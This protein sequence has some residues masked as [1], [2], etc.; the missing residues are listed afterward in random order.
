MTDMQKIEFSV[1]AKAARLIGR[2][3]I[4][5]VDG[6]LIELIKNAYDADASCVWIYFYMP[7]P[8]VPTMV[9]SLDRFVKNLSEDEL[10]FV[11]DCYET[12]DDKL[13]KKAS[14]SEAEEAQ[15]RGILFAHNKII[16]ADNGCGMTADTVKSA[17]MHIGTSNKEY[18]IRS[19]KGRVKTGAKGIG[20]FALDKLS[21]KSVVYTK[22]K[23]S[24]TVV[25]WSMD[26]D[27]FASA[28][29]I[30]EVKAEL[31]EQPDDYEQIVARVTAMKERTM[32]EEHDW[33]TGTMIILSPVREAWSG[34]LF[35]KVNTNLKSINPIGSV[36]RFEVIVNNAFYPEY[37]YKTEKVAI[38]PKDYDYRILAQF[39]GQEILKIKLLRNE[40]NLSKRKITV[41]MYGASSTRQIEEF[42]SREAFQRDGYQ[43]A[44]YDKERIIEK[45]IEN[46]I[47]PDELEKA[48]KIGPF[49]AEMYFLRNTNNEYD[50]MKRVTAGDRKRLLNQFSGVKLYRDDFKVRPYG[51]EGALYDWLGMGGRAQK[52]PA[53]ISHPSGAWRV[54]PYQMIG[55]VKIGREANPYLEDMANREGIA[56]TDTY[57]IF[58]ELLQECLKEF[59]FDR[60]YIYREYARW[61]KSIEEEL[62]DYTEKVKQEA[63]R[64]EEERRKKQKEER[65]SGNKEKEPADEMFDTVYKMMQDSERELNSKQILQ[66]LSSSGI[67]LNTFFH[68]FN[69]INTQFH[70]RASQIRSR[71]R[72]ILKGQEYTGIA[73]Y[74]PYPWIDALEKTDR[75]TAAFLDVV[76][77]GLKKE[78]L[79]R[80][81]ISM[82]K[83][84]RDILEKW[85]LLLEE[86]HIVIRPDIFAEKE[87]DDRI[88]MAVV[89]MYIILN[90][91]LLNAAW[92][93]ER[94]HNPKREIAFTLEESADMLYLYMENNGPCLDEKFKDN[95]DK[96]FEMGET[97]KKDAKTSTAG[98]GLGLWVVKETVERYNGV[99]SVMDKKDGFGL[100]IA[101]KKPERRT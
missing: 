20:R 82:Q 53:S 89:D 70:V 76:M 74:N 79:K 91:F 57:Y 45:K 51:D 14:L 36:D 24:E 75:V 68:E 95:P 16:V 33:A 25:K 84:I 85:S 22:A 58:V 38:D 6:A 40:V 42:W 97:S 32:L 29:L 37:C 7:F 90:N 77:E 93:L 49:T 1:G 10:K 62:S 71:V 65:D 5:D 35:Q 80:Q 101:W 52:S 50:I 66:I 30:N 72:H 34:R 94:E 4:A 59:E 23:A 18:D 15:L 39:D 64:R 60:Q 86:K 48:R 98:T 88:Q 44:A 43:K 27:Q 55:L 63:A 73:A 69:A 47:P 78:S 87:L 92:F 9:D 67:V 21:V 96:I 100:R 2:E 54:Q 56:L 83:V 11:L 3:N 28:K 13:K 8:D 12:E 61:I 99:I 26:W 46:I 17:W 81:E 31:E 19:D 41:E